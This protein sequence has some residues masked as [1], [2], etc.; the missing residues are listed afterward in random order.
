VTGS[1][2]LLYEIGGEAEGVGRPRNVASGHTQTASASTSR[3]KRVPAS[4][5]RS[6]HGHVKSNLRFRLLPALDGGS[7]IG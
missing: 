4:R 7:G 3:W 1:A 2:L 5:I 6:H